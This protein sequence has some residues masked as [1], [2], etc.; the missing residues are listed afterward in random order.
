M[1]LRASIRN[2]KGRINWLYFQI[3]IQDNYIFFSFEHLKRFFDFQ[4]YLLTCTSSSSLLLFL[5]LDPTLFPQPCDC[6]STVTPPGHVLT[7]GLSSIYLPINRLQKY[8]CWRTSPCDNSLYHK[9]RTS[10]QGVID[11]TQTDG[12]WILGQAYM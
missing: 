11:H 4:H 9:Y 7:A 6:P 3:S 12:L 5:F 10:F 2:L 1:Y 8:F